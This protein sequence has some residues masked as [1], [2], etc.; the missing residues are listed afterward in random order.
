ME[1][2]ISAERIRKTFRGDRGGPLAVLADLSFTVTAGEILVFLGP[3]GSGKS[4]LLR[5]L[6]GLEAASAGRVRYALGV[7]RRDFSFVFQQFALLPWLTVREN[8]ALG[9]EARGVP[10]AERG[11]IVARELRQFGL[12]LFG[13]AY[14]RDLSGG[15]RQRVGI[16]RALATD[17]KVI[18]M[19]EPF[20]ELDSFTAAE[21]R[22]ELLAMWAERRPTV[23]LVTHL[24]S[25][26]IELADRI[27]V[28]TSR[29]GRIETIVRNSLPRP[30]QTRAPEF[31]R[32][33]DQLSA[34]IRP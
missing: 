16:A 33:E 21:L 10:A 27:A 32:L 26:A 30:R 19:D 6:C 2:V 1:A 24:I 25:E 8:V 18:F 20:S 13:D 22:V 7:S 17:P 9:L 12:G 15:M 28:L 23:V 14:P 5:I 34:L 11:A 4:T 31:F 3:S 29:P